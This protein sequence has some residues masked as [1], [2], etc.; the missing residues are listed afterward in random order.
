[1]IARL[2]TL[3]LSDTRFQNSGSGDMGNKRGPEEAPLSA[4]ASG[5]GLRVQELNKLMLEAIFFANCPS[6]L[7]AN[8][9]SSWRNFLKCGQANVP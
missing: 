4:T 6:F 9:Q 5:N 7:R 1:M 8:R 2:R 3:S